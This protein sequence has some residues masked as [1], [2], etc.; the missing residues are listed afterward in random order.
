MITAA[1]PTRTPTTSPTGEAVS[2]ARAPTA[3]LTRVPAT[4]PTTNASPNC[5]VHDT[6]PY[7][8]YIPAFHTTSTINTKPC[9]K[10]SVASLTTNSLPCITD[11][12]DRDTFDGS[13]P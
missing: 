11:V 8:P 2:P 7:R 12:Y 6:R 5:N 13:S 3:F 10:P 1:F 4:F 9:Y